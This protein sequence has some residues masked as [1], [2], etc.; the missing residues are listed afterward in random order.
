MIYAKLIPILPYFYNNLQFPSTYDHAAINS[1][2]EVK[3]EIQYT[4]TQ[5]MY[6]HLYKGFSAALLLYLHIN[7]NRLALLQLLRIFCIAL[8]LNSHSSQSTSRHQFLSL[9]IIHASSTSFTT[10]LLIETLAFQ[11]K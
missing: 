6:G 2:H 5:D 3:T 1:N 4:Y 7:T 11:Q 8:L 9:V 10:E